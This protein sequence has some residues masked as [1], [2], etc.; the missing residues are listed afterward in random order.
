MIDKQMIRRYPARYIYVYVCA[1][2]DLVFLQK[3]PISRMC[4][5]Q[6]ICQRKIYAN[7]C[8]YANPHS[9]AFNNFG[10]IMF[11]LFIRR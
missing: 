8:I 2:D 7:L 4:G 5:L 10:I 3:T 11:P 6:K 9:H 1:Y